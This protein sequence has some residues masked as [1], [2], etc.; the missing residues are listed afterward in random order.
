MSNENKNSCVIS[1]IEINRNLRVVEIKK[2][3]SRK[4]KS[5]D[6]IRGIN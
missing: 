1:Q 5:A 3:G 2:R 4:L 6:D